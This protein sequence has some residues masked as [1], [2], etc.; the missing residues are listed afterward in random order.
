MKTPEQISIEK[1]EILRQ[2]EIAVDKQFFL[3]E[4]TTKYKE[5]DELR[6]SLMKKLLSLNI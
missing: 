3:E 2:M 1:E 6:N 5:L 4:D